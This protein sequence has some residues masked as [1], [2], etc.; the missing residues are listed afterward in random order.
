MILYGIAKLCRLIEECYLEV[1]GQV[2]K[3]GAVPGV[4]PNPTEQAIL[5]LVRTQP[6][7]VILVGKRHRAGM[8]T[9]SWVQRQFPNRFRNFIFVGVGKVD[10]QNHGSQEEMRRLRKTIESSLRH[11]TSYCHRHGLAA[12]Y[13][14]VFGANPIVEFTKFTQKAKE[15]YPRATC[16]AAEVIF[17]Q[18]NSSQRHR[19]R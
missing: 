4:T 1:G 3:A 7:A 18:V 5:P 17:W 14:V 9:L 19:P 6:T 16:F 8:Q 10:A 15:E 12:E 2:R 13:R 11:Y